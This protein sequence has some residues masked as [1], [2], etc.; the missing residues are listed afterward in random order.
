MNDVK[1][2]ILVPIIFDE[3]LKVPYWWLFIVTTCSSL[4]YLNIYIIIYDTFTNI[5]QF[6]D[7]ANVSN[8]PILPVN[9]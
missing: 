4:N 9:S 2:D 5:V 3:S 6:D 7:F 8:S 1:P